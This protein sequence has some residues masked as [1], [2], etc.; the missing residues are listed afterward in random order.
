MAYYIFCSEPLTVQNENQTVTV[1]VLFILKNY[2]K[3]AANIWFDCAF[4]AP[5]SPGD[6]VFSLLEFWGEAWIAFNAS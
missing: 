6:R 4:P 2:Q 3:I 5:S 1:F